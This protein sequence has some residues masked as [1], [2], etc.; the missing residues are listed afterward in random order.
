MLTEASVRCVVHLSSCCRVAACSCIVL[1]PLGVESIRLIW[2]RRECVCTASMWSHWPT[3]HVVIW[4]DLKTCCPVIYIYIYIYRDK[5]N[6][7]DLGRL[8]GW[9]HW[10]N[11]LKP[12][13]VQRNVSKRFSHQLIVQDE[14]G[15]TW[16]IHVS[17]NSPT[18]LGGDPE[19][20]FHMSSKS[21]QP[22][23]ATAY[24]N[25]FSLAHGRLD[26]HTHA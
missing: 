14:N 22:E 8:T 2:G 4:S 1:H 7:R 12:G 24:Q 9:S 10:S 16:S 18:W 6:S 13:W 11:L 25:F 26:D 17:C 20:A 19:H 5:T 21:T 23:I 3:L 15:E